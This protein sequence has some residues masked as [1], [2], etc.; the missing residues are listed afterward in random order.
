MRKITIVFLAAALLGL[1]ACQRTERAPV[2]QPQA[3]PNAM[4]SMPAAAASPG[5]G[6][7]APSSMASPEASPG[8]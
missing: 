7:P 1:A 8:K 3:S 5:T 4:A 2:A 6:M